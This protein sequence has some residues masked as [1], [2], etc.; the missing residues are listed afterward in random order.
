MILMVICLLCATVTMARK[1]SR[2]GHAHVGGGKEV[3]HQEKDVQEMVLEYM[4]RH[5]A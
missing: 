3:P 2:K 1:S 4:R 5:I